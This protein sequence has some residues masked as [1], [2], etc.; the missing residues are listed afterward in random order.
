MKKLKYIVVWMLMLGIVFKSIFLGGITKETIVKANSD[1]NTENEAID[2]ETYFQANEESLEEVLVKY[3][4]DVKKNKCIT[5]LSEMYGDSISE[6]EI[7][8]IAKIKLCSYYNIEIKDFK[9]INNIVL[10]DKSLL[11]DANDKNTYIGFN[12]LTSNNKTGYITIATHTKTPLIREINNKRLLP[13]NL[14]KIYY[15][16]EGEFYLKCNKGYKTLHGNILSTK[17]MQKLKA[18]RLKSYY[19]FTKELLASIELDNVVILNNI[20][21]LTKEVYNINDITMQKKYDGQDGE[22][23]GGISD[24]AKYLADRYGG[25]VTLKISKILSMD[26]FIC[27]NFEE[28][29]NCTLVAITRILKYY[30]KKGYNKIPSDYKKIYSKVL[31]VA[32][33]YGYSEKSGTFPTKINN[34]I[35]DVLDEYKYSKSYSKAYYIWSFSDEVKDEI[36]NNRP[37]VMNIL[38]GYYGDHSVTVCGYKIY[39]TK[40]KL[41]IAG[42]YSKTH[43]MICVYDGWKKT[44]RYID[45]EAFA[46]DLISS[47]FGSFNTV[48]MKK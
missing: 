48:I 19:S 20:I 27:N 40:H 24:P 42:S 29:N 37:V 39:K 22:G 7:I 1:Q 28:D 18:E 34:I 35:D 47:G 33:N 10:K 36:D 8:S 21:Y 45:Y 43:Q 14:N 44:V 5:S 3:S 23:Y 25:T 41:P 38:R 15:L 30:N 9:N 17:K 31:K 6:E 4:K 26:S 46:F 13:K 12:Y 32:K 11:Y 2:N 16:S